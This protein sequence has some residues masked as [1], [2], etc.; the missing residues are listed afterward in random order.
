MSKVD[1]GTGGRT[2]A[3][4]FSAHFIVGGLCLVLGGSH[5][6]RAAEGGL[7]TA[8]APWLLLVGLGLL[9]RALAVLLFG[10]RWWITK[11]QVVQS[12][13]VISRSTSITPIE[14]LSR[15]EVRQS[16][17]G[18]WLGIGAVRLE[19]DG[20]PQAV[21]LCGVRSPGS[22]AARIRS[23][24]DEGEDEHTEQDERETPSDR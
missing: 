16:W 14:R 17:I 6:S 11:D 7:L 10:T 13:G 4:H 5:W 20:S 12:A 3:L 22:V 23:L 19:G 21:T 9:V 2:S 18:R 15:V 1:T 24:C 8:L